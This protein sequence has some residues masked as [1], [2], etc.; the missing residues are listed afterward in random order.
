MA[1]YIKRIRF[2]LQKGQS[3]LKK[4]FTKSPNNYSRRDTVRGNGNGYADTERRQTTREMTSYGYNT[5]AST[6]DVRCQSTD[7]LLTS[8]TNSEG[9]YSGPPVSPTTTTTD[10]SWTSGDTLRQRGAPSAIQIDRN[11][12]TISKTEDGAAKAT[13]NGEEKTPL[14]KTLS[15]TS[16]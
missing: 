15:A 12:S 4:S 9:A 1:L 5:G 7:M 10:V 6:N 16:C 14:E 2:S 13:A 8:S 3:T 11:K